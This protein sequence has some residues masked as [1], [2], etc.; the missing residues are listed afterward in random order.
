MEFKVLV[1]ILV[2][3]IEK[4]F[5]IYIICKI[6]IMLNWRASNGLCKR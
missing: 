5:E 2:P 1:T 6:S 3:E 4:N